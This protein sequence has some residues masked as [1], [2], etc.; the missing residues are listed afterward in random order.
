VPEQRNDA[1]FLPFALLSLGRPVSP[2]L[3]VPGAEAN[4]HVRF[5]GSLGAGACRIADVVEIHQVKAPLLVESEARSER[6]LH[7]RRFVC[8]F[9]RAS[10][11]HTP[12]IV[13][14]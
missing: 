14:V 4:H 11:E 13:G 10:I 9:L 8:S 5:G 12:L 3:R 2:L 6:E 7:E 1:R